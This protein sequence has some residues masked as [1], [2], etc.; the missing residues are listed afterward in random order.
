MATIPTADALHSI[1]NEALTKNSTVSAAY[2]A[3]RLGTS[4]H[5]VMRIY[6]LEPRSI[7]LVKG[8][9][10]SWFTTPEGERKRRLDNLRN[11]GRICE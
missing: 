8:R 10:R 3:E 6:R 4:A 1:L 2:L 9:H 7:L 11:W 5:I